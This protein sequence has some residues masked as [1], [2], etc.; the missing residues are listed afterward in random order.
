MPGFHAGPEI[1]ISLTT[2]FWVATLI[3]CIIN[4]RSAKVGWILLIIFTS[5]IGALLYWIFGYG[6]A[7]QKRGQVVPP[8]QQ[9]YVPYQPDYAPSEPNYSSYE[10]GYQPIRMQDAPPITPFMA[11]REEQEEAMS[12]L[13]EQPQV[14]YPEDPR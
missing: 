3:H 4:K 10:Q 11:E 12:P 13:Y 1:F 2:V 7:K 14:M 8:V 5:W 9:S 6:F